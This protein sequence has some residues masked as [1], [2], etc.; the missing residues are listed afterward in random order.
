ML[1]TGNQP[2][3]RLARQVAWPLGA[4]SCR[5][6]DWRDRRPRLC[7]LTC[8][9]ALASIA[10]LLVYWVSPGSTV[11]AHE[12]VYPLQQTVQPTLPPRPTL[13][14]TLP[15]RP[16]LG[17]TLPPRP[18][19]A[20]TLPPRPTPGSTLAP[21]PTLVPTVITRP[22]LEPPQ[23]TDAPAPS[24]PEAQPTPEPTLEPTPAVLPVSGG[25]RRDFAA[26]QASDSA[27]P[28]TRLGALGVGLISGCGA[29]IGASLVLRRKA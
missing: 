11:L 16:T 27:S 26:R 7:V 17:P 15:P 18:T 10:G 28:L 20:P 4:K 6:V 24:P 12:A 21:R 23:P 2:D 9:L 29:L 19:L 5:H 8:L 13:A 14:P 1:T 3:A 25:T 22:T